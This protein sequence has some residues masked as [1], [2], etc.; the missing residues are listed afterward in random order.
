MHVLKYAHVDYLKCRRFGYVMILF[1]VLSVLMIT[2]SKGMP[3][4]FA[5]VE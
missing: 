5:V 4:L 2:M 1:P 3:T